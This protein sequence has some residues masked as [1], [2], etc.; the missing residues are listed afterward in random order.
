[1]P[2]ENNKMQVDI[3]TLKKQ[4]V[5][6]LLSIKELYKR[7]EEVGEK[8]TQIKY[9]DNI[10]VKKLKKEYEKL[11]KIILDEN[12][13]VKLNNDIETINVKLNNDI[14]TI[15]SQMD[16]IENDFSTLTKS[17]RKRYSNELDDTKRLQEYISQGGN[18]VLQGYF[19][20]SSPITFPNKSLTLFSNQKQGATIKAIAEFESM[21]ISSDTAIKDVSIVNIELNGNK[22]VNN[23]IEVRSGQGWNIKHNKLIN[24]N[25]SGLY[26]IKTDN[27]NYEHHIIN[28]YIRGC[29]GSQSNGIAT[30]VQANYC[31]YIGNGVS[32]MQVY[33]NNII[34]ADVL[35]HDDGANNIINNNHFFC[36][37]IPS[38]MA[39]TFIECNSHSVIKN[40]FF[41][42]PK[43]AIKL[44]Y[45]NVDISD[46]LF[47]WN[48]YI[49]IT[50]K[51]SYGAI[52]FEAGIEFNNVNIRNNS[53]DCQIDI[54]DT[55]NVNT[56][57]VGYD[58]KKNANVTI[59]NESCYIEGSINNNILYKC[60]FENAKI[61]TIT[62]NNGLRTN[63]YLYNMA[64]NFLAYSTG[65]GGEFNFKDK[66][67]TV[68]K[69][70]E[71]ALT[72]L[73]LIAR[74][75]VSISLPN[76]TVNFY[77]NS[78]EVTNSSYTIGSSTIPIKNIYSKRLILTSPNGTKYGVTVN[79]SG[80]LTTS[81]I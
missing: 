42:T 43:K 55:T 33:R 40:N 41:D 29:I 60:S 26:F 74:N 6:D 24:F 18:L 71:Y 22:K 20:I 4:N 28:N 80:S 12:I 19:E 44:T 8:T 14:E 70:L 39:S 64:L 21:F 78:L 46:N 30:E 2:K 77:N 53:Y 75:K 73:N 50:N 59:N 45:G 38:Y 62:T 66:D 15:N 23:L 25:N 16:T 3:D 54:S 36:Y 65:Q 51:N 63:F 37:P 34:N 27:M 68:T 35:I 1:M 69:F 17:L 31:I 49:D 48:P 57:K 72:Y 52:S 9:I 47:Y 81:Q 61:N 76:T 67:G 11:K 7:I 13:Q 58:I 56:N 32:D 10:L 79:D 5:N